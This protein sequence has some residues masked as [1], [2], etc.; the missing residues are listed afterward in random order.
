MTLAWKNERIQT[1]I[2]LF[3]LET[4]RRGS[5]FFEFEAFLKRINARGECCLE[6]GTYYGLS[7]MILAQY[8][9]RVVCVTLEED[10]VGRIAPRD[11]RKRIWQEVGAKNIECHE[12][13]HDSAKK[14]LL[15]T[16]DF[17][18]AYLDGDHVNSTELDYAL[19]KHCGRLLFH[20]YW[21][22]QPPVW[23]LVNSLPQDE[24][25]Y[26]D[27]DCLAYWERKKVG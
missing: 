15:R 3:G 8:F 13:Q 11:L 23:N 6:I 20:E 17:E 2:R 24:V 4:L 19:T 25:I 12:I 27:Y 26:A 21:P 14:D 5:I 16:I 7:A 10:I 1:V 22:L 18:F 9:K